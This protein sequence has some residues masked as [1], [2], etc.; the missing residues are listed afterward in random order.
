[1]SDFGIAVKAFILDHNGHLLLVKR[2][3]V[4]P[5]MPNGWDIPGGRLEPG[6][7]PLTGLQREVS[8]EVGLDIDVLMPLEVRHF[9]RDDGQKITMLVFLCNPTNLKVKL[10]SAHS[11]SK[12]TPVD[13]TNEEIP[14]WL[15]R[16]VKNY[17]LIKFNRIV[18][19][20]ETPD[21]PG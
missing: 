10:S 3:Q 21:T 20:I 6:E 4:D 9:T 2:S 14:R 12:W 18:N 17:S 1:M 11:E 7:N 16:S 19:Y 5:H 15:M 13:E 8:E